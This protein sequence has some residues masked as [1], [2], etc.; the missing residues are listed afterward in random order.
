MT[1]LTELSTIAVVA[2]I[3][4][5]ATGVIIPVMNNF[6]ARRNVKQ[7]RIDEAE[8]LELKQQREDARND[9][10]ALRVERAAATLAQETRAAA[11]KTKEVAAALVESN[12]RTTERLEIISTGQQVIHT[13]VNSD[14]TE[15]L[16]TL[17]GVM[18]V[19]VALLQELQDARVKKGEKS[20][21]SVAA[22]KAMELRINELEIIL[23]ARLKTT[24]E[25]ADKQ[26]AVEKATKEISSEP[27]MKVTL[28]EVAAN[29]TENKKTPKP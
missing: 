10:I 11:S 16:K 26:A 28:A 5:I 1:N 12:S 6:F 13:L 4:A 27:S 2:L 15:Q 29:V 8:A 14:K 19:N 21:T 24:A 17:L 20:P 9:A 18:K 7:T 22:I 3:P 23:D 25:V